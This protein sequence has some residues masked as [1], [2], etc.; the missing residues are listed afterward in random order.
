MR[1]ALNGLEVAVL[2]TEI[3]S[4]GYIHITNE[5]AKECVQERKAIFDKKGDSHYDNIS[6]FIK[7][8]RGS[9]P[10]AAIFYLA[11]ALNGGEDPVFLLGELLL[12]LQKM[13]V[14]QIQM[15]LLLL[16]PQCKLY[17]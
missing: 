14:W 15:H 7:S 11:R 9:D 10:D 4:D 12:Q 5:I 8:M 3:S 1:T 16:H 6:A 2:T 17:I 13:L